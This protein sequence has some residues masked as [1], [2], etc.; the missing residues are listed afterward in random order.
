[1]NR[2]ERKAA[3]LEM[4]RDPRWQKLRLQVFER[5]GWKC[6]ECFSAS[7]TLH[8]HHLFYADG[9][10]WMT[11]EFALITLC[12]DCHEMA[13]H[14]RS[15]SDINT[16]VWNAFILADTVFNKGVDILDFAYCVS[17]LTPDQIKS[18]FNLQ[19]GSMDEQRQTP[20]SPVLRG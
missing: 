12:E 1:M 3:Y 17:L 8:V 9:P 15:D 4:L 6:R 11:P 20:G 2:E 5:D 13:G 10:P 18:L 14:F 7:K 16:F 19:E